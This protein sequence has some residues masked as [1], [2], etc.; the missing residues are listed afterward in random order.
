[1]RDSKRRARGGHNE[2]V[3]PRG[4]RASFIINL[5]REFPDREFSLKQLASASGG[6]TK[7]GRYMVRDVVDALIEQGVVESRG[8]DKYR[9][10]ASQLPHYEGVVDM[11]ASGA[12]YVR[13][14]ELEGDIYINQRNINYALEGDRV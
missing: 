9:L 5:F 11:V 6:N 14:E 2:Q 8:R 1:M 10:S 4:L 3:E 12:A 7:Q 13:V